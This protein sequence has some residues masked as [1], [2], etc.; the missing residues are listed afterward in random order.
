MDVEKR[1]RESGIVL[2]EVN[3]PLA[4]YV[5]AVRS[6]NLLFISGQ[7]P[8]DQG[9]LSYKGKVG[10]ELS[11]EEGQSACRQ[12][13]INCLA[14]LK[15]NL[16][17]WG[18]LVRIVKI[19]GYIRCDSD[20]TAQPQVLNGASQL[21]ENLFG[22]NGKHARAAV[23]VNALPLGAACEVEMVVELR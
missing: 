12:A 2:T 19:T 3:A 22:V 16:A 21:L 10:S 9:I 4:A 8:M 14:V 18:Q 17:D 5:P 20:F 11:I 7:L 13:A 6:G 23:G 15:K 1:L